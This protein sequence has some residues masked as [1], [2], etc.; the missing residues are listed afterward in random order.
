MIAILAG[1]L[2]SSAEPME[3]GNLDP[4]GS[5]VMTATELNGQPTRF[6]P[7][8]SQAA[9]EADI[10]R[11]Q[12]LTRVSNGHCQPEEDKYLQHPL[13]GQPPDPVR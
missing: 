5:W 8:S 3:L 4:P 6:G 9:C 12:K 10:P 7:Y 13:P 2:L 1:L 11:I